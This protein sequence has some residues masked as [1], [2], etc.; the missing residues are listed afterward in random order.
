MI[1]SRAALALSAVTL[2]S[3]TLGVG[4]VD[5]TTPDCDASYC[6]P[7][8]AVDGGD[9]QP[10]DA[11]VDGLADAASDVTT[12]ASSDA[13]ADTSAPDVHTDAPSGG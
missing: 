11:S 12:D 9:A 2:G 5:G 1:V 8:A 13:P 6:G 3:I 7:P 10:L 4:C